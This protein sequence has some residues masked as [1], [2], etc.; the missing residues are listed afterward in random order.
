[1]LFRNNNGEFVGLSADGEDKIEVI[2]EVIICILNEQLFHFINTVHSMY[3]TNT[4]RN[5]SASL[6]ILL[7]TDGH[8][9]TGLCG[10]PRHGDHGDGGC[11]SS[12]RTGRHYFILYSVQYSF[13]QCTQWPTTWRSRRRRM[14]Q[15]FQDRSSLLYTIQCTV[16]MH[17]VYTMTCNMEI[18]EMEDVYLI[19]FPD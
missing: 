17:T 14:L 18:T 6:F 10:D 1:M 12:S 5:I 15:L 4:L 13:T 11:S 7:W 8:I 16:L 9:E 2:S 19:K 3:L